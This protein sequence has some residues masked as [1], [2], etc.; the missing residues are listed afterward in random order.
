MSINWD[1]LAQEYWGLINVPGTGAD[2]SIRAL[3]GRAASKFPKDNPEALSWF[4]SAL[5][6]SPQ[7]WFVAKVMALITPLPHAMFDPLLLAALLEPNPSATRVF[8][9]PCVRSFGAAQV[10]TRVAQLSGT[11]GV[12][13]ND[14]VQKVMYWVPRTDS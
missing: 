10:E 5:Q 3:V 1:N 14:G 6:C 8:V 13:E 7:K 9:E 2:A 11:P 12:A 4:T